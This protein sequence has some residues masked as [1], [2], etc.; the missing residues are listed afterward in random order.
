MGA[1]VQHINQGTKEEILETEQKK[2]TGQ[3]LPIRSIARHD[4]SR[5]WFGL[6]SETG[7]FSNTALHCRMSV[8]QGY[9]GFVSCS[10]NQRT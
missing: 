4:L 10:R 3:C 9:H 2:T 5:P 1:Y 7:R 8:F 6:P